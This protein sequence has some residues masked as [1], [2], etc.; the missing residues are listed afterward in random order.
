VATTPC[1]ENH[2]ATFPGKLIEPCSLARSRVN[3]AILDPFMGIG[4]TR[5]VAMALD[6]RYIECELNPAYIEMEERRYA[7]RM[8]RS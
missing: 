6:R 1:S 2:F 4:T 3:D 7:D 5:Q 8:A